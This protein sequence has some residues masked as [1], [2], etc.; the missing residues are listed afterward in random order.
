MSLPIKL[1]STDFDGTLHAD[2]ETPPVPHDLQELI[3]DLQRQ[4]AKW[5]INTGRD[6]T[7]VM[8]GIARARL[9][10]RPDYLVVVE[11]EIYIHD[12]SQYVPSEDWNR[13]CTEDHAELFARVIPDVPRIVD[14]VNKRF[15]ATIYEDPYS[16]FCLIAQNNADADAIQHYLE[17]YA[18]QVMNLT[19]V[20]NDIYARFS[21]V[22]YNKGT[23][24]AEVGRQLGVTR[25]H[26]FAA[27]DHLNDLPML[28]EDFARCLVAPDNAIPV[29]KE[30][31]KS[32]KGYISH[33]PWGHGVA[34][35]LEYYLEQAGSVA[36][37]K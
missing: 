35:G 21:H 13:R 30:R 4:G 11:R 26:T 18:A 16:P 23:A 25:E 3:G 10:I 2:F 24:L 29:V 33:Q 17:E 8:E 14:W 9:N 34:R 1:I 15:T 12:N 5:A 7:G 20:R 28:C 36:K 19:V 6:L 22:A 37:G 27:G 31:V 32:Q